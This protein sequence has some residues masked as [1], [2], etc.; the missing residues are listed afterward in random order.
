MIAKED[1]ESW[2]ENPVTEAVFA[3]IKALGDGA[4]AEWVQAS[5]GNGVLDPAVL[6]ALKA[7]EQVTNDLVTMTY[8]DLEAWLQ[9]P[10]SE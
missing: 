5:W 8:E 6:S 7:K 2:L 1:F 10:N 3:S 4:K 9:Q